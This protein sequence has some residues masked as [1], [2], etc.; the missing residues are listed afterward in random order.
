ML[1]QT[2]SSTPRKAAK[3]GRKPKSSAPSNFCRICASSF[4]ICLGNLGETSYLSAGNI[5]WRCYTVW[6]SPTTMSKTQL[7]AENLYSITYF[8]IL[9]PKSPLLSSENKLVFR[10]AN[11]Q[12]HVLLCLLCWQSDGRNPKL[13]HLFW[14]LSAFAHL[15]FFCR[16]VELIYQ[17]FLKAGQQNCNN[18]FWPKKMNSSPCLFILELRNTEISLNRILF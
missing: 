14:F 3:R 18:V 4:A 15:H 1:S 10:F 6:H 16:C 5:F 13:F 7:L 8:G 17:T 9:Y 11:Q 2:T 12:K